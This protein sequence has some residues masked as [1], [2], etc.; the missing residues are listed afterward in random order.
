MRQKRKI[1]K[2]NKISIM[3]LFQYCLNITLTDELAVTMIDFLITLFLSHSTKL[4]LLTMIIFGLRLRIGLPS[5]LTPQYSQKQIH[6]SHFNFLK[7]SQI[8]QLQIRIT[9]QTLAQIRSFFSF[10]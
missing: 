4:I 6:L 2:S 7:N 8:G 3:L 5:F 10:N 1:F 9:Q